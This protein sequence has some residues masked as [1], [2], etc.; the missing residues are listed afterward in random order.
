MGREVKMPRVGDRYTTGRGVKIT[1]RS[2][3]IPC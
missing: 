3:D 1:G 2:D